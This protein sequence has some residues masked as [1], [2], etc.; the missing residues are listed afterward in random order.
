MSAKRHIIALSGA[1]V[2]SVIASPASAEGAY[3]GGFVGAASVDDTDLSGIG[4]LSFDTGLIVGGVIGGHLSDNLRIE[5]ELSYL[6]ADAE[7]GPGKCS[8]IE[9][10]VSTLSILGN[11]W[12]D[13]ATDSG[14][15]PYVGGGIGM[16][17]VNIES[18]IG[19]GD[20]WGFAYQIGAGV[21]FGETGAF[22]V[23]Y[24]YRGVSVEIDDLS[25]DDIETNAHVLQVGWTRRF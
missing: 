17:Q 23:G 15:K 13:F 3:W 9:F 19:D 5:G 1:I 16:A 7:C 6:S 21:R 18:S 4:E 22:D 2:A 11:G 14:F 10:D 24:R 8:S 25:G 12:Y 20:E